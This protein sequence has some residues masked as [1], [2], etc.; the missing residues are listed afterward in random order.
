[1]TRFGL[2]LGVQAWLLGAGAAA[3]ATLDQEACAR[4][5][6]ELLQLELAGTRNNMGKGPDWAKGNLS[7]DK[8]LQIKRLLD[9]EE[10]LLFRCQ[11]KPLVVLPEGVE[12][13]PPQPADRAKEGALPTKAGEA[14]AAKEPQPPGKAQAKQPASKGPAAKAPSAPAAGAEKAPSAAAAGQPRPK[15]KA[16]AKVDDAYRPPPATTPVSPGA[17]KP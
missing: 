3:A 6:T 16:K 11:G 4:L 14:K 10:Q 13:E 7:A 2:V 17:A 5:K 12:A 1:M 15:P 8:L 9:V